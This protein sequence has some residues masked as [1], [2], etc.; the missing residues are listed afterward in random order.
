MS[1][2]S[3]CVVKSSWNGSFL[4]LPDDESISYFPVKNLATEPKVSYVALSFKNSHILK[5]L[6]LRSIVK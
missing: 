6:Y 1:N 4:Y 5:I 2:E 3:S